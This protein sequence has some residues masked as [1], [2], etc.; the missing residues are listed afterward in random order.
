MIIADSPFIA[1]FLIFLFAIPSP[2][3][4]ALVSRIIISKF[5][6]L[7][8]YRRIMKE[9]REF[10]SEFI[11]AVR[12]KDTQKLN[13]LQAKKPYIDKMKWQTLRI[14]FLNLTILIIPFYLFFIWLYQTF[15][16]IQ[17]IAFF[18]LFSHEIGFVAWYM[19]CTFFISLL[20]NRI[21]GIYSY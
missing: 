14:N 19:I 5:F 15:S 21:L 6:G 12:N 9:I 10:D 16:L 2:L 8:R 13:K 17:G 20:I 7:E 1:T 11:K 4:S 3:I 18:P